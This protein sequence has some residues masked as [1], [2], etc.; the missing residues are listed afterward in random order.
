MN[1]NNKRTAEE[2]GLKPLTTSGQLR[3]AD[4]VDA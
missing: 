2:A 4:D 1:N 3:A